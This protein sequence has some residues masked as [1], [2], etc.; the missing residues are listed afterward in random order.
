MVSFMFFAATFVHGQGGNG[1][2]LGG[3]TTRGTLLKPQTP[4]A[5]LNAGVQCMIQKLNLKIQTGNDDLRGGNNNLDVEVH[6][7][8]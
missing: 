4:G 8:Q 5:Q 7:A 3:Q 6:N 1:T 2:L